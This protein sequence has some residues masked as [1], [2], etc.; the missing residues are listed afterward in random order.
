MSSVA[1]FHYHFYQPPREN[2]WT[3]VFDHEWS[4]WPYHDWNERIA[5]ECY[6]AMIAVALPDE[7]GVTL[8]E[9]LTQSSF[10][11]GPTLHHWL[12]HAAPD[13][14]RALGAQVRAVG[15]ERVVLAAPLVHAILPLATRVDA[16][17][18]IVWGIDDYRARYGASPRGMWLPETAVDLECLELMAS[19]G[20]GYTVVMPTQARRV[21]DGAGQW[22]EVSA[23]DLD[24][25][26]AYFVALPSGATK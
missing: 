6:R 9:P 4:A 7:E 21:R 26:R 11:L 23:S 2:P 15:A 22:R 16:R 25:S 5:A 18:L 8:F 19:E 3:G 17:R 24:T 13:V 12:E 10:D 20:I 14:D 1:G